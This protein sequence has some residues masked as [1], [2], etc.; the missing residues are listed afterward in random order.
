M[1]CVPARFDHVTITAAD[2]AASLRV[3]RRGARRRSGWSGCTNWATRRR[4]TPT[5]EAAAFGPTDGAPVLWLVSGPVPTRGLHIALRAD[6]RAD[7]ERFHAAALAAGGTSRSAPRRWP[8]FR[9]GE[10]NAHR[11]PTRTATCV[12]AVSGE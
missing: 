3:L 2:F 6:Q 4:T 10:F 9:R 1:A 5:V 12:E 11:A 7:V 8:I